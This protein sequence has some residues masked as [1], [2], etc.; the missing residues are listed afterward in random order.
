[1][2]KLSPTQWLR[3]ASK[4]CTPGAADRVAIRTRIPSEDASMEFAMPM[5]RDRFARA[6][7]A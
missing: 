5:R 7:S 2:P 1:M 3:G 6:A 4:D